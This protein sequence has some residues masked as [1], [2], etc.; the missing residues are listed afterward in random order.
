MRK[1]VLTVAAIAAL[2]FLFAQAPP[3]A[4]KKG[5]NH[6]L[7]FKD[8]PMLPGL[9]YH[10]H[11]P[12]RPHPKVVTPSAEPGGPPSDALVLFAGRDLSHWQSV[13]S[14]ITKKGTSGTPEWK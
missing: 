13:A 14:P 6:D 9:P 12:D 11:D 1:T 10:V 7:G 5:E 3:Q 2:P 4:T 8:T